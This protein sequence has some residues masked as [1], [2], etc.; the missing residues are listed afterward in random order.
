MCQ[1]LWR[2]NFFQLSRNKLKTLDVSSNLAL[3]ILNVPYNGLESLD[4][5]NSLYRLDA[6]NN[7]LVSLDLSGAHVLGELLVK[8]NNIESLDLS[9]NPDLRQVDVSLNNLEI[10]NMSNHPELTSLI[11]HDNNL[12]SL[13]VLGAPILETLEAHGNPLAVEDINR[14]RELGISGFTYSKDG[15]LYAELNWQETYYDE[16]WYPYY[17]EYSATVEI[18][19]NNDIAPEYFL[20]RARMNDDDTMN[21]YVEFEHEYSELRQAL[22]D[23]GVKVDGN[24]FTTDDIRVNDEYEYSQHATA[25]YRLGWLIGLDAPITSNHVFIQIDFTPYVP[26]FC[27]DCN[28]ED[29]ICPC[30]CGTCITCDP[31]VIVEPEPDPC[32]PED[33][34]EE[35]TCPRCEPL[36]VYQPPGSDPLGNLI[37][38]PILWALAGIFAIFGILFIIIGVNKRKEKEKKATTAKT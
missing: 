16:L 34:C 37:R 21:I 32:T 17:E 1:V 14:I 13:D 33:P 38:N 35:K 3:G 2:W 7:S 29:C 18:K 22:G 5:S 19:M 28:Q 31:P 26:D 8:N 30:T 15:L 25:E 10:L 4:L 27:D 6:R 36:I 23:V 11:V 20:F 24:I 9:N 12:T